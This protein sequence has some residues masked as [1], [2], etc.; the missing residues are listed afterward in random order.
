MNDNF[1]NPEMND[2]FSSQEMNAKFN[3]ALLFKA[4]LA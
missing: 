4:S 1:R 3:W 2:K